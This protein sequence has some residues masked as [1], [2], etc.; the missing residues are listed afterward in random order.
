MKQ[1]IRIVLA[2]ALF[3]VGVLAGDKNTAPNLSEGSC[4]ATVLGIDSVLIE[5]INKKKAH[6]RLIFPKGAVLQATKS[7]AY[8]RKGVWTIVVPATNGQRTAKTLDHAMWVKG[9]EVDWGIDNRV[10]IT[11]ITY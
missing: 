6:V 5:V 3:S 9:F 1:I 11:E 4:Y 8:T 2:V 10:F 7:I